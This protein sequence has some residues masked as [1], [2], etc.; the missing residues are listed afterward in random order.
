MI[1]VILERYLTLMQGAENLYATTPAIKK[2]PFASPLFADSLRDLPPICIQC[3][4]H[5][6]LRDE[7][8]DFVVKFANEVEKPGII[9][10]DIYE[11][12]SNDTGTVPCVHDLYTMQVVRYIYRQDCCVHQRSV[13]KRQS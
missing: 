10:L 11:V 2:D 1:I 8:I 12:C 7:S 13:G 4:S 5:E 3:G 9:S 6:V